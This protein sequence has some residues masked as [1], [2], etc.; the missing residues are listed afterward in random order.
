MLL[1]DRLGVRIP[2]DAWM[3]NLE[4]PLSVGHDANGNATRTLASDRGGMIRI[5]I[6][7]F[8]S[9]DDP[10]YEKESRLTSLEGFRATVEFVVRATLDA[11]AWR[12]CWDIIDEAIEEKFG[13]VDDS[14]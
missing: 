11:P 7:D 2:E 4:V 10:Q 8:D 5:F 12:E 9:F 1:A 13:P 3:V 14:E 6:G